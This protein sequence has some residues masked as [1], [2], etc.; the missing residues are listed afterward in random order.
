MSTDALLQVAG[1]SVRYETDH[2]HIDA[3]QELDLDLI[4]GE[5]LGIVG[6]SGSGKS[7]LLLAIMGLLASTA[8]AR[9][10]IRFRGTELID[11][12]TRAF[13]RLRGA[14]LAMIFQDPLSALNP[15][16]RV[17]DQ[18]S[19]VARVH[20]RCARREAERRGLELM[21]SVHINEPD[22][23]ARQYPH[24]LSGGMRQRV[25]IAMA[26]MAEPEIILAD[27]PTTALDATVQ[28]QILSLLHEVR[29]RSGASLLLVT[30]D[31]GVLA[32]LADRVG[33][34][35]AGRLLELASCEQLFYSPT[36]PYTRE[37]LAAMPKLRVPA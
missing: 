12:P 14:R 29:V 32:Q 15:Y 25:M 16:L 13:N 26:L 9:G 1:L 2:G 24:E 3:I 17:I 6:E 33:V 28:A 34:M 36:H 37:L 8:R 11:L 4:R 10:S 20:L 5:C 21:A 30:H 19:E 35:R 22:R 27:E 7:A 31:L 23:R 18:L